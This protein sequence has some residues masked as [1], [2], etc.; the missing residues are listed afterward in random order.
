[1]TWKHVMLVAIVLMLAACRAPGME[2]AAVAADK[3][4]MGSVAEKEAA[5]APMAAMNVISYDSL[6]AEVVIDKLLFFPP[7]IH[8]KPGTTVTWTN[9]DSAEHTV[10]WHSKNEPTKVT[11]SDVLKTG[12]KYSYTFNN[13]GVY[14]Y[15]CGIHP[16]M[17]G[18]II[19]GN[20]PE[21]K[22]MMAAAEDTPPPIVESI[23]PDK[24]S[25]KGGEKVIVK[26]TNF[27]KGTTVFFHH[28]F[29]TVELVDTNT[30]E[31]VTPEHYDTRMDIIVTNPDGDHATLVDKFEYVVKEPPET[32]PIALSGEKRT[33][34]FTG[35]TPSHGAT[36]QSPAM[37][38]ISFNY[39]IVKSSS[40]ILYDAQGTELAKGSVTFSRLGLEIEEVPVLQAGAYT[41][42][43][44]AVW[45]G[46]TA[47]DGE[48]SFSVQ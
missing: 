35:S 36:V 22:G 2:K 44:H 34:H 8:I 1:M 4:V 25:T 24:V 30:L 19:V 12:D 21:M 45:L 7:F 31:V 16:F 20:P 23:T 3:E 40:I 17:I 5:P 6:M 33:P 47:H 39:P 32:A 46:G 18:G 41:V 37:I 27:V 38:S 43:Y 26:G 29:G 48:F 11:E 15:I 28:V 14:D 10:A 42:K 13:E 9:R